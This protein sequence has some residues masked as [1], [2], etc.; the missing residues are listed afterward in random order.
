MASIPFLFFWGLFILFLLV[1]FLVYE[2]TGL[3]LGG[4]LVLPLL[5]IYALIDLK[6]LIVFGLAS[7]FSF[8]S[9][10]I[11][12]RRT[13]LYGRRLLY[14][15]LTTGILATAA[16]HSMVP[17]D[18]GVFILAILPGLFA[19]NLHREGRYVEGFAAFAFWLGVLL[20]AS[21]AA[22][23]VLLRPDDGLP[24]VAFVLPGLLSTVASPMLATPLLSAFASIDW[25]SLMLLGALGLPEGP[26]I[27]ATGGVAF[28]HEHLPGD[29]GE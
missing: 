3:R 7:A 9:G 6:I 27:T 13:L 19:Y 18:F 26:L 14:V 10:H 5:V 29:I 22:L 11:V 21:A 1:G 2:K 23:W 16:F 28:V 24:A 8:W 12:Y 20:V 15:F 25:P 4:I 17:T